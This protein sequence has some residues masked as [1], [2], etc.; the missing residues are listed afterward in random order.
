MADKAKE[1]IRIYEPAGDA[2]GFF[3]SL[4]TAWTEIFF[5]RHVIWHLFKRDFVAQ[6]RQK[7]LGYFWVVIAPL[8]AILPFVF[9]YRTGILNPGETPMP[10]P[11]Y[12]VIGMGIWGFLS[13]VFVVV[14]GGLQGNQDLI[15][16][17]NIPK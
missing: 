4:K 2:K 3:G 5:S 16:K 7:L 13:N 9:L 14:S 6:F 15:M 11:I 12:I 1:L 8:L 10:Y 17:T